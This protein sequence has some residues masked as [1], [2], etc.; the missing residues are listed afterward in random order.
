MGWSKTSQPD[1]GHPNGAP[2]TTG[3]PSG[4]QPFCDGAGLKI[5]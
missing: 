4:V 5:R 3:G 2:G 1:I